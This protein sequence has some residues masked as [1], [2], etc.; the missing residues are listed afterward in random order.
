MI[1]FYSYYNRK[2]LDNEQYAELIRLL[3]NGWFT[4]EVLPIEHIIKRNSWCAYHYA[5]DVMKKR[6]IEA[7]PRIMKSPDYAYCYAASVIKGRWFE[8]EPYIKEYSYWW[9]LYCEYFDMQ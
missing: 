4:E 2:G 3:K 7:E 1:N 6:W 8:A 5:K 9:N